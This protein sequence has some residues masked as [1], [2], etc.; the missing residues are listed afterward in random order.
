MHPLLTSYFSFVRNLIYKQEEGCSVGIDLGTNE[1]KLIELAKNGE[2]YLVVNAA[3]VPTAGEDLKPIIKKL[4]EHLSMPCKFLYA[5]IS[6]KGTL[7]R[8]INMPKM[9]L[10]DLKNSFNIEADKYF[11]FPQDQI[12]TDCFILNDSQKG[13]QMNVMAVAAKRELVD[14]R[15][16]LLSELELPADFIG[17]NAVANAN[18]FHMLNKSPVEENKAIAVLNLGQSL[19]SLTILEENLPKF[20]RDIFIGSIEIT[21]RISNALGVSLEEAE[22]LK[23]NPGERKEQISSVVESALMNIIQEIRLSFDYFSTEKNK[24][25]SAILLTG[26]GAKLEN[27]CPI[28][29]RNLEIKTSIW[30]PLSLIKK[31]PGITD[32]FISQNGCKFG[33]ALGLALYHYD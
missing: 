27:I 2:D 17:I 24:E 10:K 16:K 33:V 9:T 11:P 21:K 20:N 1:C 29:E 30:N 22:I 4:L 19:S 32:D 25:I 7:V 12:Y 14:Q 8:Y 23:Q 31:S 3:V 5:S 6:G 15:I 26:G 18:V 13:N 28:F